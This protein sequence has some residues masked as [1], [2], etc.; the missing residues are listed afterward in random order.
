[1]QEYIQYM[2]EPVV[3]ILKNVAIVYC[4]Y[5]LLNCLMQLGTMR[6]MYTIP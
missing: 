1:M 5:N 3:L 2:M 6:Y 4:T